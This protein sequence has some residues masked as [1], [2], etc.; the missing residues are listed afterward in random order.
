MRNV[1]DE[2]P[3]YFFRMAAQGLDDVMLFVHD[4][5]QSVLVAREAVV[6]SWIVVKAC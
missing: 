6:W 2:S 1:L 3:Y 5:R 4:R